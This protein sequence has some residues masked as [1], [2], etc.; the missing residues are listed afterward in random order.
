MHNLI[1]VVIAM[2]L[3]LNS[4]GLFTQLQQSGLNNMK[5]AQTAQQWKQV[6]DA[7]NQY[8]QVNA[9]AVAAVATPTVPVTITV[10]MLQA[11]NFLPASFTN[12]NP[13]GQTWVAET[14]QPVAG[15][16]QT[17]VFS[18]GATTIPGQQMSS[19]ANLVSS[20]AGMQG[21]FV[22]YALE[23]GPAT[24]TTSAQGP[25]WTVPL[26]NYVQDGSG[27]LAGL[28]YYN[29]NNQATTYLNRSA[30]A[31]NPSVNTMSTPLI[32]G[33]VAAVG[34]GC[35][36][37]GSI[38]QDG[39]GAILS[40]PTALTWTA[41]GGGQW[42]LPAASYATLP[43]AGNTVGDVRLA[44]D[45]NLA[46]AWT[47]ATW[48]AIA[49]DNSGNI[50]I[51]GTATMANAAITGTATVGNACAPNGLIA[52]D[53]TGLILSCQSGVWSKQASGSNVGG[54]VLF[55]PGYPHYF[56][57]VGNYNSTTSTFSGTLTC[58]PV[59]YGTN[60]GTQ[61]LIMGIY[62]CGS[63][64]NCVWTYAR[65]NYYFPGGGNGIVAVVNL[66]VSL[67]AQRW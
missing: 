51:P 26:A 23:F 40:C 24:V 3:T 6:A 1:G 7:T 12:T 17:L 30:I 55:V 52:Q 45:K 2:L 11:T 39:N 54:W 4:F 21:G 50:N 66:A 9:G 10:A 56:Y 36:T 60:C 53:G 32:M 5:V 38:A 35:T 42:K 43:A 14:L 58:D 64:P 44:T 34:T 25:N 8:L 16:L 47:G 61:G 28:I 27:H 65:N 63:D 49:V 57:G 59:S 33:A 15:Q 19:L 29:I 67:F 37:V 22:P 18:R 31:G 20:P 13:Y 41:V 48:Q 62:W 46:Y